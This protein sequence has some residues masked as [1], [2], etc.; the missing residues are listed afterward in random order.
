[1]VLFTALMILL[2]AVALFA[3]GLFTVGLS[4]VFAFAFVYADVIICVALV[5]WIVRYFVKKKKK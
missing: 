3:I 5:V 4:G 1:M 2:A